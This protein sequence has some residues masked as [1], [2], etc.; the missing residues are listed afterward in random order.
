M[1]RCSPIPRFAIFRVS[2]NGPP[3]V[4]EPFRVTAARMR[5][6]GRELAD[7]HVSSGGLETYYFFV[8][9]DGGIRKGAGDRCS[10]NTSGDDFLFGDAAP[11]P[12][13]MP[14]TMAR[15][16]SHK[17]F[18]WATS[19]SRSNLFIWRERNNLSCGRR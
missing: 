11:T 19:K 15:S 17:P 9:E 13:M 16:L 18:F 1:F 12:S 4:I 6:Q 10:H 2:N 8:V 7:Q 5:S 3:V 14:L